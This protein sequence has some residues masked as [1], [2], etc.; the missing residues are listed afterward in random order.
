MKSIFLIL[1]LFLMN[2]ATSQENIHEVKITSIDSTTNYYFI[3][4]T[5][6]KEKHK[7]ILIVSKKQSIVVDCEK[8]KKKGTYF[9]NL[10]N[11]LTESDINKLPVKPEGS[12]K[13]REDG[14]IIWD[15]CG[16]FPYKAL[17]VNS[18]CVTKIEKI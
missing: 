12:L 6:K 7:K 11:Y 2:Q 18:L 9:F 5:L 17:N 15:G 1:T 4:G 13:L 14:Y 16:S 10:F 8:I 3:K